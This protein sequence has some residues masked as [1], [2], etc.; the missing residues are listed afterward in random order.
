MSFWKVGSHRIYHVLVQRFSSAKL[1]LLLQTV[2][3]QNKFDDLTVHI[4]FVKF[5]KIGVANV[6]CFFSMDKQSNDSLRY[7][8]IPNNMR[9]TETPQNKILVRGFGISLFDI[10]TMLKTQSIYSLPQQFKAFY[11]WLLKEILG[12]K[13]SVWVSIITCCISSSPCQEEK[14]R[15]SGHQKMMRGTEHFLSVNFWIMSY[16]PS[17]IRSFL[18]LRNF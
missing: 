7:P 13:L 17:V 14:C 5:K 16:F 18:S 15:Q 12:M 4:C 1:W 9:S 2:F 6:K 11:C 8:T 10:Q 3:I